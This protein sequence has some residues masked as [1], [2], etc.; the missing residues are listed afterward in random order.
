M[1]LMG[2]CVC[3]GTYYQTWKPTRQHKFPTNLSQCP[4]GHQ[5]LKAQWAALTSNLPSSSSGTTSFYQRYLRKLA[6]ETNHIESTFL[7]T[8]ESARDIVQRGV[9]NGDVR[10][11][12]ESALQDASKIRSILRDTLAACELLLPLVE[13]PA[14]LDSAALC[15]IHETLVESCRI[16]E[17][18]YISPGVTRSTTRK[19]VIVASRA[20]SI[21][22]CPFDQ[23][24]AELDVICNLAK[25]WTQTWRN[26]FATASWIHLIL[27]RCHPFEDGNGRLTRLIAS[28]PLMKHGYPP[29]SIDL[30]QRPEYYDAINKAYT[31]DH[32]ALSQCIIQGA[33]ETIKFVQSVK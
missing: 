18:A 7:I 6:I 9:D 28:L 11:C 19:T 12:Y 24:D 2:F 14:K 16:T 8:E 31:G 27:V 13:D 4:P 33:E 25:Q 26:P 17:S 10:W 15:R 22:C 1:P 5:E 23:V 30:K 21:Q 3:V 29:I 20:Y 32:S